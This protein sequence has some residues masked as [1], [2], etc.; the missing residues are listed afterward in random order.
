MSA[1]LDKADLQGLLDTSPFTRFLSVTVTDCNPDAGTVTLRLPSRLEIQRMD[2]STQIHGGPIAALID[3]A[4]D[5]VV[6]Q[7]VGGAVPTI[8]MKVDYLRPVI[9]DWVEAHAKT[10]R[11]GR[12]VGV[13]DVD[14]LDAEGRLCAVGR[15]VYSA[16]IG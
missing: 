5:L 13:A 10:R 9:G 16:K 14:L 11:V 15:A 12:T 8:D 7:A 3:T 1:P 6:A 4:G 2:G